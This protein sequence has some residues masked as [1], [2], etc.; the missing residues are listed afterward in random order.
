MEHKF[1]KIIMNFLELF[2]FLSEFFQSYWS[3]QKHQDSTSGKGP[4]LEG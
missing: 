4:G 1:N 2:F 3:E